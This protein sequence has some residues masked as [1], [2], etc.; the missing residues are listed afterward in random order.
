MVKGRNV[1]HRCGAY[2]KASDAKVRM[3]RMREGVSKYRYV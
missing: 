3:D 2:H 1:G